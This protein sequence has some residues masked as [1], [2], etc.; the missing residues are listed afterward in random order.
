MAIMLPTPLL[1]ASFLLYGALN[2]YRAMTPP[3]RPAAQDEKKQA[4]VPDFLGGMSSLQR[5]AIGTVKLIFCALAVAEATVLLAQQLPPHSFLPS[6]VSELL[7]VP[8]LDRLSLRLTAT[9]LVGSLFAIIGGQIRVQCFRTLG[10]LFTFELAIREGHK[11]VTTGPYGVVRHP[12]YTGGI[13]VVIGNLMLLY[14]TGSFFVESGLLGSVWG[15]A[16]A[17]LVTLEMCWLSGL[18]VYRTVSEDTF[19][20]KQ[21]GEQWDEWAQQTPYRLIPWLY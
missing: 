5:N 12:S 15:K 6:V 1:K 4:F 3:T 13:M 2:T 20:S 17:A 7:Q 19:L 8:G 18:Q 16:L 14:G 21:F 9:S 11:L 10:R